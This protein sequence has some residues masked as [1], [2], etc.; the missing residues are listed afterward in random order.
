MTN[1]PGDSVRPASKL[2]SITAS[3]PAARALTMS[4]EYLM[5]PSAMMVTPWRWA[6]PAQSWMAVI[7]G[8]PTPVTT[9]VVQMEP[10]PTPTLTTSAPAEIRSRVP[11]AV[12]TFP[13]TSDR[14]G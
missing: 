10:A 8:M 14:S 7:W 3:A 12:T 11:S 4:P 5:P 1:S 6:S 9:R 13:A 2:P